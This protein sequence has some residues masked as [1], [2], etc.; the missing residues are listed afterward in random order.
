MSNTIDTNGLTLGQKAGLKRAEM[1]AKRAQQ[2]NRLLFHARKIKAEDK[3]SIVAGRAMLDRKMF[4]TFTNEIVIV[5]DIGD[6]TL[7]LIPRA[8]DYIPVLVNEK[9]LGRNGKLPIM[10]KNV[11]MLPHLPGRLLTINSYSLE[12]NEKTKDEDKEIM[13]KIVR[14]KLMYVVSEEH[15][16]VVY[17]TTMTEWL[18]YV[19]YAGLGNAQKITTRIFACSY[20]KHTSKHYCKGGTKL[21]ANTIYES[22]ITQDGNAIVSL[23]LANRCFN[24][25]ANSTMLIGQVVQVQG[26]IPVN[27]KLCHFKGEAEVHAKLF[28]DNSQMIAAHLKLLGT[29]SCTKAVVAKKATEPFVSM[30]WSKGK[31]EAAI[32]VETTWLCLNGI[33]EAMISA[34]TIKMEA[35]K[36]RSALECLADFDADDSELLADIRGISSPAIVDFLALA[37]CNVKLKNEFINTMAKKLRLP[38]SKRCSIKPLQTMEQILSISKESYEWIKNYKGDKMPL[39]FQ[40]CG[41]IAYCL[42]EHFE[43]VLH[44]AWGSLDGDDKGEFIATSADGNLDNVI[45]FRHPTGLH[46]ACQFVSFNETKDKFTYYPMVSVRKR[47]ELP[48]TEAHD[49]YV[50]WDKPIWTK[51]K[52]DKLIE[53][54][55][56]PFATLE[57][58]KAAIGKPT[59][60][61]FGALRNPGTDIA[62]AVWLDN[63]FGNYE[64]DT[65]ASCAN[66]SSDM[67]DNET[68]KII[69]VWDRI[70]GEYRAHE[71]AVNNIKTFVSLIKSQLVPVPESLAGKVPS[72]LVGKVL[73]YKDALVEP[74]A[75][76]KQLI[77]DYAVSLDK[78]LEEACLNARAYISEI[79]PEIYQYTAGYM[80]MEHKTAK[81]SKLTDVK[82]LIGEHVEK[83][84]KERMRAIAVSDEQQN[85]ELMQ[86]IGYDVL[87]GS[88]LSTYI[89]DDKPRHG[90]YMV[91]QDKFFYLAAGGLIRSA[92]Q[93]LR[94]IEII[95]VNTVMDDVGADQLCRVS[96]DNYD[97]MLRCDDF[98]KTNPTVT[99]S[100]FTY[101]TPAS[102]KDKALNVV[103]GDIVQKTIYVYSKPQVLDK[104][105]PPIPF[106]VELQAQLD[107]LFSQSE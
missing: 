46:G 63:M 55:A 103:H 68:G 35:A 24:L 20:L 10:S 79:K 70:T 72:N 86:S 37:R 11:V 60:N 28:D 31:K 57:Q 14:S 69:P 94:K 49:P 99:K 17:G 87:K 88:I 71:Q 52:K 106:T 33:V 19:G 43:H 85:Q 1:L 62:G 12:V 74:L 4:I 83:A 8:G 96:Y 38:G 66:D 92:C 36:S 107:W 98:W 64:K 18:D 45:G 73:F 80:A 6:L 81:T 47:A 104:Q 25:P 67:L 2:A 77:A 21:D 90:S 16:H 97:H 101:N 59:D 56:K 22:A 30:V 50:C 26:L 91:G 95:D 48:L 61:M 29:G 34:L 105:F 3:A 44:K 82:F 23:T 42:P 40:R 7:E 27:G 15:V 5:D 41:K 78:R 51:A 65:K 102:F 89:V 53:K 39:V 76:L 84:F 58:F 13:E 54:L 75:K 9:Y 100:V 32:S 93:K